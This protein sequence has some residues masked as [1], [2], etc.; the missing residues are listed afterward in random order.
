MKTQELNEKEQQEITGGSALGNGLL[1]NNGNSLNIETGGFINISNTD[2]E[3]NT[4]SHS[5]DFGNSSSAQSQ[6]GR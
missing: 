4:S 6:D 2:D 5:I 3:G 1:G